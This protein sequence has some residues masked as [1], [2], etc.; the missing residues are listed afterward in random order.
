[1]PICDTLSLAD[2]VGPFVGVFSECVT[3]T[4][5]FGGTKRKQSAK[6]FW[7]V[8]R[9]PQETLFIQALNEHMVPV[10]DKRPLS[11]D[12]FLANYCPEPDLFLGL[13]RPR[14]RQIEEAVL[15]GDKHR[16]QEEFFSA[17]MEYSCALQINADEIRA[18]F[19]LGLTYLARGDTDKACYVF[20]KLMSLEASYQPEHKHL[21][22]EFGIALRK[23]R[24]FKEALL[25]YSR[26][27]E[28]A[29]D[30][31]HL[32][33]NLARA[34]FELLDFDESH[35]CVQKALNLNPRL[36]AAEQLLR[37][38]I[39]ADPSLMTADHR[40]RNLTERPAA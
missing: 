10:G 23:G 14:M 30:D 29:E 26:A 25:Y 33:Y 38:L 27:L 28:L 2:N 34:H 19:G 39:R 20:S 7:L 17:E 31:D 12:R 8:E 24:M 40:I 37:I 32:L 9:T 6:T 36:A 5:G 11:R 35:A 13:V 3:H 16:A 15:R 21:F 22:N 1:M 18:N 4:L